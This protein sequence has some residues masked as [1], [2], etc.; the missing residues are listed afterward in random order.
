[1]AER[2]F[3]GSSISPNHTM[4][5]LSGAP[6]RPQAGGRDAMGTWRFSLG[7][8]ASSQSMSEHRT[9]QMFPCSSMRF[10][11]PASRWR[12]SMFWVTRV[13]RGTRASMAARA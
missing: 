1:M 11:E 9:R 13:N 8:R 6:Q 7:K 2:R 5:G 4:W 12:L 3:S 10:F